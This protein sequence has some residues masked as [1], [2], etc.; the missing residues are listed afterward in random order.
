MT[1]VNSKQLKKPISGSFTGSFSGDGSG[2]INISSSISASF[3]IT[4]SYALNVPLTASY[5]LTAST[6]VSASYVATASYVINAQTASYINQA[7][8]ASYWSGSIINAATASYV[9]TAQTAS[10]VLNVVSASYASTSSFAND[11]TVG[12][13]LTAQRIVVQTISASVEYS[14]G[15]N[16]FGS[17]LTDT[18]TFTGSVNITGSLTVNGVNYIN[19]SS[20]FDQRISA[21]S[22]SI[23]LLSSSFLNFS[24]SYNTGSFTG[25]FIG[26]HTGS[27]SGS[28]YNLQN[29]IVGHIPFF[30]SSQVLADSIARQIDNGNGS[31]SIVI[32]QNGVTTAAPEALY[33]WQPST[34]SYNV[35]SG[36]GN[37]NNYLQLN[38]QNTNT[39]TTA[40]SDVVATANN[41]NESVNY[42][43]MGIN[44]VNFSGS[45]GDSNDAYLYSTGNDLHIGNA[46]NFPIQFFAGGID[47]NANRKLQ[48]D[49]SNLHQM[50]GSLDVSG[51]IVARSFTG[52]L[53]G[54]ASWANNALTASYALNIPV[55]ASYAVSS[56]NAVN[57]QTASYVLNAVTASYWSGSI[58]NTTSASYT[59]TSSY[60]DNFTVGNTL[61]AQRIVVQTISSSVSYSS[62]S[63]IFGSLLT[64]TQTFTGSV[65]MTGSLIVA[66]RLGVGSSISSLVN[67]IINRPITGG[68][69]GFGVYQNGI[70][71]SDVTTGIGFYNTI[72]TQAATFSTNYRHYQA[73]NG[74]IGSGSTV[75]TQI[76]FFVQDLNQATSNYA[77]YSNMT[78]GSGKYNLYMNG[79]AQNYLAGNLGIGYPSNAGTTLYISKNITGATVSYGMLNS[80]TVQ[81]D[82]T[83]NAF[84][85]RT[86][87]TTQATTFT[88]AD[89][90]HYRASINTGLGSG[91]IVTTQHGFYADSGIVGATNNYGFR[92]AISSST[93]RWNLYMDGTAD[94]YL[95]GRLGIGKTPSST[96]D[97][98]GSAIITGSLN[99]TAG[100]T[101]SLLGTAATASYVNNAQ[102][103]SYVLQAVSAS[104]AATTNTS[105]L[106]TTGS[107]IFKGNQTVTGSLFIS[108]STIIIGTTNFSNSSTTISGSLLITGS[109]TQIGNNTISGNTV[110][111]GS[112]T[113]S[114]SQPG[115][116]TNIN[117]YGDTSI[118]GAIK[119]LPLVENIDTVVSASYIYVSGSTNDL[120]F[121]QN[122]NGYANTTRLRWLEGNLY[123]GLL[124]GGLITSQSS[125]VYQINSG[126]GII[127]NLNASIANNPYPTVEYVNWSNLSASIA[128]TSASYDQTFIGVQSGGT[129]YAQ[130]TPF[131]AG[132]FDTLIPIGIVLH[133]NH[134]TINGVKTQPS[135]A[136][137]FKQR[138]NIFTRAFGPLKLSGFTV[139]PSGSSTGSLVIGSGTAYQ[140]GANYPIDPNNPSYVTDAGTSV[141]KIFRYY[142]SGSQWVYNTNNGAGYPTIDP[143]N[144]SN[145]G[146][147]ATVGA[148]NYSIQRV[149]WYPNS[150]TKAIVVYYGNA[151]YGTLS[152]AVS[153]LNVESFSEAPNTA[154]N[155][156]YLG[157]YA[158]KGGNNTTLQNTNHFTWLAGGLFRGVSGAG[159]G[160]STVTTTLFGLSDVSLSGPLDHQ[161]LAYDTTA[162]KWKNL[163]Y[164]SASISG[165]A[166][167]ATTASYANTLQGQGSAAFATTASFNLTSAS[168]SS[169]ITNT[170]VTASTL[171][172]AS[173][174]YSTRVTNAEATLAASG[175]IS[176]SV[177]LRLTNTEATASTLTNAS[178]SFSSRTTLTEASSSILWNASASYSTRVTGLEAASSSFST[179]ITSLVAQ[180]SSY[181]TTGS[182]KFIGNQEITGSLVT[183]ANITAAGTLT[184]QTLVVQTVSS[185][186]LYSSGSNIFGNDLTNTQVFTGSVSITGSLNINNNLVVTGSVT[187]TGAIARSI[188]N[189]PT[190]VAS[191][192][193]DILV[194]LD[195]NPTFT[196][197]SFT[198]LSRLAG[199]F[200]GNVLMGQVPASL[201]AYSYVPLTLSNNAM[202]ALRTQLSLVNS[203][204][205]T[206]A[207]SAI[208][209]FTY[210]DAGNGNPA[211]RIAGVDDGF[212]S[213]NFQILTKV[214]G[215]S[216][217][218]AL[219]NKFQI[220]GGTGN[221]VIQNAGTFTDAG[222]KLDVNGSTR[223]TNGLTV[224]GSLNAP[225][226]TGSLLGTASTAS[227]VQ[228]AQT[229][230]YVVTAQTASY[231][232]TA[233][234][235]SYVLQA[236]SASYASSALSASYAATSSY[237][238]SFT[239]ANTFTFDGTLNDYSSVAS[240]IVG[241]NNIFT[242]ATGSYRGAFYKY[243]LYNGTNARSGEIMA[244]WNAGSV[245]YTDVSTLDIGTTTDVTS[246]V[247]IVTAQA[248]LNFQTN[249]SGWTIKVLSTYI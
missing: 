192:N 218:G 202:A 99:V 148:S 229:A 181:A 245:Q 129:I 223:I 144:Y 80:G 106:A 248:Q 58:L 21:N 10:Y 235:A 88:L 61:T 180:T 1:L 216:G 243:T 126:S 247:A 160:G 184:A 53:Q 79:T 155:A 27:F 84:G 121:T 228:T 138:S 117:I 110:I 133:Q 18:Q 76:G 38:I 97:V 236:V 246:S 17:L 68:T 190:L 114:G 241:S 69:S 124:N 49:P 43:D 72:N 29:S 42:I 208:D 167:T 153:N 89:L 57:A 187:A 96:L 125:T 3:A 170:E 70:V 52:S 119:F 213:N 120:Y 244:V 5:A 113:V 34:S 183:T 123:T 186:V 82:V 238:N 44:S 91:S 240:S 189:N 63:N 215:S 23:S 165:N 141:S 206:G 46:S 128:P 231:V 210:T 66:G 32:N 220:F 249:T 59:S 77:F 35:V 74:T 157:A 179:R 162:G 71:Q 41:G 130:G 194:G 11:F 116:A 13:T 174:S 176:S 188:Y 51:S 85:Y 200:T 7:Q 196:T 163:S 118:N 139:A 177:S 65:G 12:N 107:N 226:I 94:N 115:A 127:V 15:S 50:T 168:V 152:D 225:S 191:A 20:S 103:A 204:G 219:T 169:R 156:V 158:I 24:S 195:V 101:G 234:T 86:F 6:A 102:T 39:G 172:N 16:R 173:A 4:A 30:S 37:L 25:S 209:F 145:N 2:L 212:F 193:N 40:S 134:S 111:S 164:I 230:S 75:G 90:T 48:L 197:G 182:N 26:R 140:D 78:T 185:S 19:A 28:L 100:I 227:Y 92:G 31:Y 22:S 199:R 108:G 171:T 239:V 201:L 159:G 60:A 112:L 131:V 203:G 47:N 147:L 232:V 8:S 83:S 221:V 154:A 54:T 222:F 64:D 142:Q 207:G 211:L 98:S 146:T 166:D 14:S 67:L 150:T 104:Y 56:S 151:I 73:D 242:Q 136:Y 33:V 198:G 87:L 237:A 36:K 62:G 217:N 122:G 9:Q 137:G 132:Q 135:L 214:Q 93:G 224:T 161:P 149:Y 81:S 45:V 175:P 109:T 233:Q 55:T 105:S 95:A 178:S 205:S 143:V